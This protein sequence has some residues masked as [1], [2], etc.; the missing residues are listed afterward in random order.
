M[1]NHDKSKRERTVN[2]TSDE[3]LL[4]INI[5]A[6]YKDIVENKKTDAV[7][8]R[9]KKIAWEKITEDF[10]SSGLYCPRS[11]DSLKR[12]YENKKKQLRREAGEDKR[13]LY[14]TGGGLPPKIKKD[15]CDEILLSI[16]N[17]K[18]IY[19]LTNSFDSDAMPSTPNPINENNNEV[20]MIFVEG[21]DTDEEIKSYTNIEENINIEVKDINKFVLIKNILTIYFIFVEVPRYIL[22][23]KII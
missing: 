2:F 3:K 7:G 9:E 13:E 4:L 11:C 21:E 1:E 12:L 20:E 6:K 10:N 17:T 5:V 8:I 22:T 18:T 14:K 19:G 23:Y 16:I 15:A